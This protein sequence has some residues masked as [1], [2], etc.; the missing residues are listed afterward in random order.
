V[1]SVLDSISNIL[2]HHGYKIFA[3]Y[4]TLLGAVREGDFIGHDHDV[5]MGVISSSSDPLNAAEMISEIATILIFHG[6]DVRHENVCLWVTDKN[7]GVKIDVYHLYFDNSEVLQLLWGVC[8]TVP[9]KKSDFTGYEAVS[10]GGRRIRS[11][12]NPERLL[13]WTYG[14]NWRIPNP[15]H[16]WARD[17]LS[18]GK[19]GRPS[20]EQSAAVYWANHYTHHALQYP[21]SFGEF[22][23][24]GALAGRSVIDIGCGNGRDTLLFTGSRTCVIAIDSSD[25]AIRACDRLVKSRPRLASFRS[26]CADVLSEGVLEDAA[27]DARKR[28]RG[29][30][31]TF[32]GRFLLHALNPDER[33][34]FFDL[35]NKTSQKGDIA[36]FEF[37]SLE[38]EKLKKQHRYYGGRF[39]V[40]S[41]E[42]TSNLLKNGWRVLVEASGTGFSP[43]Y[44]EDPYL[45][46]VVAV[47]DK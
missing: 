24:S 17:R 32:Y 4:G 10:I 5:D 21:S 31:I 35:L 30:R 22:V 41:G 44:S 9:Y 47:R 42:I 23:C 1:F 37:R 11:V 19:G 2:L 7:S 25:H 16:S 33:K 39:F 28:A 8:G 45:A 43:Y 13:E 6:Y 40:D 3:L 15:G 26:I 12:S 46:R 14:P 29:G 18:K 27:N 36:A 34:L 38:D 20:R